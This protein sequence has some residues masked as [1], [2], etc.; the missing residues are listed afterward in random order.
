[1]SANS[2]LEDCL[3]IHSKLFNHR[4]FIQTE[5]KNFVRE[6]E[7]KRGDREVDSVF[8][9]LERVSELR[10]IGLPQLSDHVTKSP[11][12]TNLLANL[13]VSE[14]MFSR[15]LEQED[16]KEVEATLAASREVR[17][18]DWKAFLQDSQTRCARIDQSFKEQEESIRKKYQ[19]LQFAK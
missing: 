15:I 8:S 19:D 7:S 10:D 16:S 4:P 1:M 2:G 5:I 17:D 13:Q 12:T 9:C 11:V 14:S 6:F 3:E 18:R